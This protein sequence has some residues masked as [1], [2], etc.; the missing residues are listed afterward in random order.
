MPLCT[1]ITI[2]DNEVRC[3]LNARLTAS[4][5]ILTVVDRLDPEKVCTYTVAIA[6]RAVL[7]IHKRLSTFLSNLDPE[8]I[9]IFGSRTNTLPR[10][11]EFCLSN[12]EEE[13]NLFRLCVDK[14]GFG[15]VC[16]MWLS[17]A[18]ILNIFNE[19]VRLHMP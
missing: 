8:Q 15:T 14:P 6:K 4:Y 12:K 13:E 10:Y 7:H 19:A 17:R 18:V 11:F 3:D 16:T 1:E 2:Q 5:L 9:V